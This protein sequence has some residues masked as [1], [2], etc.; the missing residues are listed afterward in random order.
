MTGVRRPFFGFV[1]VGVIGSTLLLFSRGANGEPN[2]F[3]TGLVT[4]VLANIGGVSSSST[5]RPTKIFSNTLETPSGL[6]IP[7]DPGVGGDN[8]PISNKSGA[9]CTRLIGLGVGS[10][11]TSRHAVELDRQA[12][13]TES[14]SGEDIVVR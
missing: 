9:D 4:G 7:D 12:A 13:R 5:S 3:P 10:S 2:L 14:C 6:R 8:F 11:G 1:L